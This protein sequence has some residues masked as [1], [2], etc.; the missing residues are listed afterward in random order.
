MSIFSP[1][2]SKRKLQVPPSLSVARAEIL[3]VIKKN[4]G[5]KNN[6]IA[7]KLGYEFDLGNS[8][9]GRFVRGIVDSLVMERIVERPNSDSTKR[10]SKRDSKRDSK[11]GSTECWISGTRKK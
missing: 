10:G 2:K 11:R 9:K 5:I 4:P 1:D 7:K 6:D 3:D 8:Q